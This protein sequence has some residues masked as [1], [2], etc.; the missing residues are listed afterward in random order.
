MQETTLII[1]SSNS[2][3]HP[4]KAQSI[5]WSSLCEKLSEVNIGFKEGAG[6]VAANI[7]DGQRKSER[8]KST[9][10][11]VFDIDNKESVITQIELENAIRDNAYN[12]ILHSTYNHTSANPRF[13]LILDISEPIKPADHKPLLLHIA[14]NLGL[15]DFIDTAC[16]DLA[17]Y[18]YLPRCP[19]ERVG[20]YV[21]WTND[22]N[23][24]NIQACLD[25]IKCDKKTLRSNQSVKANSGVRDWQENEA[26]IAK[27][28]ELL[29]YCSASFKYPKWRNIIWSVTSLGWDSGAEILREWSMTSPTHWYGN[30]AQTTEE[31]LQGLIEDFD[32]GGGISIG[33]LVEEARKGGWTPSSPFNDLLDSFDNRVG[34]IDPLE[35]LQQRFCIIDTHGDIRILDRD[36]IDNACNGSYKGEISFYKKLDGELMMRRFLETLSIS[37]K[38]K[39][40]I[41]NFWINRG[42]LLYDQTAFTPNITPLNTLNYWV[43]QTISPATNDDYAI[44]NDYLLEVICNG[45]SATHFYLLRFLAHMLQFPETK[46]GIVPVLIGGQGTGKG[47]FFQLLKAIWSRTTLLVSDVDEV[48][49]K[50]NAALERHY[51]VCMDEALFSGDKKSLDRLKSLVTEPT[52]RIEQKYQP[53]RSIDSVHRFFAATNHDQ[54]AHIEKDD[55]R[56]FFLRVSSSHQQDTD[57]FKRLCDSFNDGQTL[58]GFVS[59]LLCLDLA[60]FNVRERPKTTEHDC[61]RIKSL[62]GFDRY[63]YEVLLNA[64]F[65]AGDTF[66][67]DHWEA[68]RFIAT[69][70]M[71]GHYKVYDHKAGKY[72]PIQAG[73]ISQSVKRLCPTAKS[74]RKLHNNRPQRGF[75]LPSIQI[76]RSDFESHFS[77]AIDWE[78]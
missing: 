13:R 29:G 70:S 1:A 11:L 37:S 21:Y 67:Q 51:V 58:E 24:V 30:R 27:I 72:E 45:D 6:W 66:T 8:V 25:R 57:Y 32:P 78:E 10:L 60:D 50:F 71:V 55:R 76:A 44:I 22:G 46:P 38:P 64:N 56:F 4:I 34:S 59:F 74:T 54:F 73:N 26:N 69:R 3:G 41:S 9:S 39:E 75:N 43:G 19:E 47:V 20:D 65:G 35:L 5:F 31:D 33:T 63:W 53:S 17:R 77:I 52:I 15:S 40:V 61:Q 7:P 48:V 42:T 62:N 28:K 2:H 14:Q 49:G 36:Q 12:A 68:G 16:T 23:P 18:F